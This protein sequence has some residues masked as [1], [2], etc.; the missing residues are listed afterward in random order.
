MQK[1]IFINWN[2]IVLKVMTPKRRC[3][4]CRKLLSESELKN[5]PIYGPICKE[6]YYKMENKNIY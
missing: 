5:H 2:F 3:R 1:H 4:Y 6:C